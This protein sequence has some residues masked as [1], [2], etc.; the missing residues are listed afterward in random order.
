MVQLQ[1]ILGIFEAII[2]FHK[3]AQF[4]LFYF[5]EGG[6]NANNCVLFVDNAQ[7]RTLKRVQKREQNYFMISIM[8]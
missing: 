5:F 1:M 2:N 7:L 4:I 3:F 6:C 8:L